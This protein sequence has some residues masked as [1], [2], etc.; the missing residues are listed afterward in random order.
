MDV[1]EPR[2]AVHA[3]LPPSRTTAP[4]I[5]L[6]PLKRPPTQLHPAARG[7]TGRRTVVA[8]QFGLRRVS[9]RGC[10]SSHGAKWTLQP[11]RPNPATR[12]S[13]RLPRLH[14]N[15][16]MVS[17]EL[18]AEHGYVAAVAVAYCLTL[19]WMGMGVG[20]ARKAYNVPYPTMYLERVR[21]H[22]DVGGR[23]VCWAPRRAPRS[24]ARQGRDTWNVRNRDAGRARL[25]PCGGPSGPSFSCNHWA[26]GSRRACLCGRTR[27]NGGV[28]QTFDRPVLLCLHT[29]CHRFPPTQD[30]KHANIF[31]C[32]QRAHQ[33]SL[34]YHTTVRAV[35]PAGGPGGP[36]SAVTPPRSSTP[37]W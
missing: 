35:P 2:H 4:S 28:C 37:C 27:W 23:A 22:C 25:R 9:G 30:H 16:P 5:A 15:F 7:R 31:N 33:N 3:A 17:I 1:R 29:P 12:H 34:E 24:R 8:A 36:R 20:R 6:R 32:I 10:A 19:T 11:G 26:L 18:G 14:L 21:I 13:S